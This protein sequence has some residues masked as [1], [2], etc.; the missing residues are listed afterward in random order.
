MRTTRVN[1]LGVTVDN[2]NLRLIEEAP[3]QRAAMK[4]PKIFLDGVRYEISKRDDVKRN[5]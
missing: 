5:T 2:N 1:N 3:K 4:I